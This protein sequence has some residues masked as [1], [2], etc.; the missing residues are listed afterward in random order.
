[1]VMQS[2]APDRTSLPA[3]TDYGAS[4]PIGDATVRRTVPTHLTNH[5]IVV[6]FPSF[7]FLQ[8]FFFQSQGLFNQPANEVVCLERGKCAS[9]SCLTPC[10]GV[11]SLKMC[12]SINEQSHLRC[13]ASLFDRKCHHQKLSGRQNAL[14]DTKIRNACVGFLKWHWIISDAYFV[15]IRS[16]LFYPVHTRNI[17]RGHRR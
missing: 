11:H 5:L 1:M 10:V 6:S 3:P 9:F 4:R 12:N 16:C 14:Q 8:F 2:S 13:L 17:Y 7:I 15:L